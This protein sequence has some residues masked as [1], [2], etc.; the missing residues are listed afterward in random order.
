MKINADITIYVRS[1]DNTVRFEFRDRDAAV[2]FM[3]VKISSNEFMQGLR[4]LACIPV[5]VNVCDLDKITKKLQLDTIEFRMPENVGYQDE[6]E[7]ARNLAIKYCPE[8]WVPDLHFSSQDSFFYR[9]ASLEDETRVKWART[10]IRSWVDK[11][12]KE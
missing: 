3:E 4:G 12:E 9:R 7:T 10:T 11:N 2:R 6:K 8:G 5:D 1:D